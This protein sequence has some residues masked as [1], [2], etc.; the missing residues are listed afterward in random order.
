MMGGFVKY[1]IGPNE[2]YG[3][4]EGHTMR[5]D[6]RMRV[7][8]NNVDGVASYVTGH[9]YSRPEMFIAGSE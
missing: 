2:G 7:L 3:E 9:A 8:S 4:V 6:L 1:H 5:G